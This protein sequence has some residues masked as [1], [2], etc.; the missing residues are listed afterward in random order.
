M[1]FREPNQVKW[2]GS[3]PGHN[4]TQVLVQGAAENN[5]HTF[6]TVPVGQTFYWT[7]AAISYV[8]LAAG[9][10]S[11]TI[12]DNLAAF[13]CYVA[14]DILV[15]A[16][17]TPGRAFNMCPPLEIPAGYTIRLTSGA[18]GLRIRCIIHGWVE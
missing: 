9:A 11:L 12:Y 7:F 16:V 15:A 14:G 5:T 1:H 8:G 2:V 3:R 4:G 10:V 18:I 6:Y 17:N 13:V